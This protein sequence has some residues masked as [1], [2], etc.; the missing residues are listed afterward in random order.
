M[1]S[2]NAVLLMV[3]PSG[4]EN[5]L[6]GHGA[7]GCVVQLC[8]RIAQ[9]TKAQIGVFVSSVGIAPQLVSGEKGLQLRRI[10]IGEGIGRI[11]QLEIGWH[12]RQ[13]RNAAS[14]ARRV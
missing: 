9:E 14:R 2:V 10:M 13:T 5:L 1:A 4:F 11:L 7:V 12:P 8:Q 3:M 6:L